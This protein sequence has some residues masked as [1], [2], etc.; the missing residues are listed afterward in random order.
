[1]TDYEVK[2]LPLGYCLKCML[3]GC[4]PWNRNPALL[5]SEMGGLVIAIKVKGELTDSC[6]AF[7]L[8]TE[9]TWKTYLQDLK[10]EAI[11]IEELRCKAM[12][13]KVTTNQLLPTEYVTKKK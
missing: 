3:N 12:Q 6:L 5:C 9:E 4:Y 1:M 2:A 13:G 7:K 10:K 11:Y 8:V